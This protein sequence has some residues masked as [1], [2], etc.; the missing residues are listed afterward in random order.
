MDSFARY[1]QYLLNVSSQSQAFPADQKLTYINDV[2][3][4]IWAELNAPPFELANSSFLVKVE[5]IISNRISR[6]PWKG[7]GIV[8]VD[9][10]AVVRGVR[11]KFD[12]NNYKF[13]NDKDMLSN[14]KS[15]SI[16]HKFLL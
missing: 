16:F 5:D 10:S 1:K 2:V 13:I 12:D 7:K 14:S 9:A 11:R 4:N 3:E 6:L 15:L 8:I